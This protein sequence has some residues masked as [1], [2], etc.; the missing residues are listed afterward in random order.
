MKINL[1]I[2]IGFLCL[3]LLTPSV[4]GQHRKRIKRSNGMRFSFFDSTIDSLENQIMDD[5]FFYGG[6]QLMSHVTTLGRDNNV[7]QWAL[8]P[9]VGFQKHNLDIYINGF[10]W[11]KTVPKY[12]ETDAG[13]S[14]LWQISK[15]LALITSYEHAFIRFGSDD[16][17]YTINNLISTTFSWT[18]KFFDLNTRYEYDWGR[19]SA[20]IFELSIGHQWNL[21]DVFVKDKVEI[22]PRFYVSY[23][24]GNTYPGRFFYPNP[25]Y[26]T[27]T[28]KSFQLANYEIELPVTWRKIGN[29]EWHVSLN[30]AMPQHV[31]PEEGDG[32]TSFYMTSSLVKI[33]SLRKHLRK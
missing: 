8:N 23:L 16:D 31:L 29:I 32:R 18:N 26:S 22:T 17:K 12:A 15:P 7:N 33:I 11:S 28:S 14:K 24:G 19:G 25:L 13:I 27:N 3:I 20:S 1:R 4:S 21:F 30:F 10:C 9:L 2:F 5:G 6:A